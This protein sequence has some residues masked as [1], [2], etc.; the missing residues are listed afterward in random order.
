M[1]GG[2]Q[3]K[4]SDFD[5]MELLIHDTLITASRP[6]RWMWDDSAMDARKL[7]PLAVRTVVKTTGTTSKKAGAAPLTV[8]LNHGYGAP[9]DDLVAMAGGIDA[10]AGTTFVFPEAPLTLSD[11]TMPFLGDARAWWPIDISR[12]ERAIRQGTLEDLMKDEPEGM[13]SAREAL[14]ATLDALEKETPGT[15]VVLGGFS[16]GS[17]IATDV[18]L[19]TK[20]P[21]AGLVILSGTLLAA[22]E[23][24]PGMA[25]RTGLRVFQSHGKDDPILPFALA[26]LLHRAMVEAGLDSSFLPFEGGHGIPPMVMRDLGA[27]LH[28]LP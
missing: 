14:V 24:L 9:G 16:Q 18:A 15:R 19:R 5:D 23:W 7:G 6:P 2:Q 21:L 1:G 10:P 11:P 22:N 4:L 17:M 20:R 8:V 13:A 28:Q 25:S 3:S 27:F 26:Q 12:Y